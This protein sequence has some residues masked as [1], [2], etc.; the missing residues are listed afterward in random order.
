MTLLIDSVDQLG[1]VCMDRKSGK[2][3]ESFFEIK[4][5]PIKYTNAPRFKFINNDKAKTEYA[6]QLE[7]EVED[8]NQDLFRRFDVPDLSAHERCYISKFQQLGFWRKKF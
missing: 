1:E 2:I 5:L 6:E 7:E 8:E 3:Q 4:G